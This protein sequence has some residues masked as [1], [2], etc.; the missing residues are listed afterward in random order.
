MSGARVLLVGGANEMFVYRTAVCLVDAGHDVGVLTTERWSSLRTSKLI[1][2]VSHVDPDVLGGD[3]DIVSVALARVIAEHRAEVVFATDLPALAACQRALPTLLVPS[4]A[5]PSS[6]V[7][8]ACHDKGRFA[9]LLDEIGVP[10]PTGTQVLAGRA[11][12]D[13]AV[14]DWPAIVKPVDGDGGIGVARLDGH[15]DLVAH[16]RS[17]G[18]GTGFPLLVQEFVPGVDIDCSFYAEDGTILAWAVQRPVAGEDALEFLLDERVVDVCRRLVAA[19]A[20]DGLG[21]AD[22]RVDERDGSIRCIELNP[23]V[24][25]SVHFAHA[26][27][28]NFPD[29]AVRRALGDRDLTLRPPVGTCTN[30]PLDRVAALRGV[31]GLPFAVPPALDRASAALYRTKHADPVPM[32][33][34]RMRSRLWHARQRGRARSRDGASVRRAARHASG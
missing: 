8:G 22:L 27:G 2:R 24:W 1:G 3:D 23:R 34:Q 15:G 5:M 6:D 17:G 9:D 31:L 28:A 26:A 11:E 32:T 18:P 10:A 14:V 33:I 16:V 20:Y 12:V 29:L 25:G 21:H 30:S 7:V 4:V 19:L 13:A